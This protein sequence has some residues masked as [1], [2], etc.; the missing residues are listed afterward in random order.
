[1][2]AKKELFR[3]ISFANVHFNAL[4]QTYA[5]AMAVLNKSNMRSPVHMLGLYLRTMRGI[6]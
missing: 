5:A 6:Q 1:M 4:C 2:P 3:S